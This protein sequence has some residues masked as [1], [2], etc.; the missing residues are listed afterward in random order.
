MVVKFEFGVIL[1]C[2]HQIY[3]CLSHHIQI[4][5]RLKLLASSNNSILHGL[6]Y[7][8]KYEFDRLYTLNLQ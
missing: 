2:L 1:G 5:F 8:V 4:N 3:S 7:L 6:K